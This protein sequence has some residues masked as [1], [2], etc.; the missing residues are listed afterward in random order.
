ME[1]VGRAAVQRQTEQRGRERFDAP[2]GN[3]QDAWQR[4]LLREGEEGRVGVAEAV[5]EE[6]DRG[7]GFGRGRV[8]DGYME[9]RGQ[10]GEVFRL[11]DAGLRHGSWVVFVVCDF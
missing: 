1:V 6:E 5:E 8:V 9:V 3:G 10:G 4:K 7:G 2:D 11:G